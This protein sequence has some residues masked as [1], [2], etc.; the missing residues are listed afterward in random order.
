[1]TAQDT[2]PKVDGDV[3]YASEINR[4]SR[5]PQFITISNTSGLTLASG[6]DYQNAGSVLI[7]VG[8]LSNPCSLSIFGLCVGYGAA[9]TALKIQFS[10]LSGNAEVTMNDDSALTDFF[11]KGDI[12]LGSPFGNSLAGMKFNYATVDTDAATASYNSNRFLEGFNPGS[13]TVILFKQRVS[14]ISGNSS[15]SIQAYRGT[16]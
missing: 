2:F 12:L 5:A 13:P 10:G 9:A 1:M 14:S 4:F 3:L 8:S 15:Y 6:T 11:Y 7:G 16:Y